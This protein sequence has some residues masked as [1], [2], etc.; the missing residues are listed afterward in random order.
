MKKKY[1][2]LGLV[3]LFLVYTGLYFSNSLKYFDYKIYDIASN[4]IQK[5]KNYG[6]SYVTIVDIDEKS[7]K[8][9]GQWP[10]SRLILA[11]LIKSISRHYPASIS[12]DIIFP[13]E[14]KTSPKMIKEFYKKFLSKNISIKGLDK[15][16]MDNDKIFGY[17]ISK[18]K[19]ILPI[20]ASSS[21][22]FDKKCFLPEK[23]RSIAFKSFYPPKA[24]SILCNIPI[25]QKNA[26]MVGF[27]NIK[28]DEDGRL[29][30]V[31]TFVDYKGYAIP[32][33]ALASLLANS[34]ITHKDG[35]FSILGHSFKTDEASNILLNF[36]NKKNYK[37][38]SAVDILQNN[39][40]PKQIMGKNI[41]IGTTAVGLHDNIMVTTGEIYPGV[42]IHAAIIDNILQD[43]SICQPSYQKY[44]ALSLSVLLSIIFTFLLYRKKYIK[45]LL[46]FFISILIYIF[47]TWYMLKLGVYISSGYF[48]GTLVTFFILINLFFIVLYYNNKREFRKELYNAQYSTIESMAL[49]VETRDTETGEHIKRT[50]IYMKIIGEY[51]FEKRIF[52]DILT[53]EFIELLYRATPLHD[54]GKVGIPDYILKKEG[55][56]TKEEY[57]IMQ[58]H[59]TIGNDIIENAI[60]EN[61]NNKFLKV[62]RNIA[63]YHHEKWDGSGYPTGISKDQ[64]PLEARMMALVDIYDALISRRCYKDALGFEESEQIIISGSGKHFD[65]VIVEAFIKLKDKFKK[66]ALEIT[67]KPSC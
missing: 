13:E 47:A 24:N 3:I 55:K 50:K 54:I 4:F 34:T 56:L 8:T 45:L 66:I 23:N 10:W 7:L 64:I 46:L 42:F 32:S 12:F 28:T 41:I 49:V 52:P 22:K 16:L 25:L 18:T 57:I 58:Q 19:T 26:Y 67:D 1:F 43:L 61:Q 33:L 40:S 48:F 51:L 14:D 62:A 15:I 44:I 27:M 21:S 30:R 29:R 31:P 11:Q 36:K 39:V 63:Y 20:Y 60:K 38:V 59:P 53:K 37:T 6:K 9:L 2:A 35:M 17:Q 65:P 5:D